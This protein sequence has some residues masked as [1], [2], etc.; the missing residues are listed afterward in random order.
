[1]MAATLTSA[2]FVTADSYAENPVQVRSVQPKQLTPAQIGTS[3]GDGRL[4]FLQPAVFDPLAERPDFAGKGIQPR[5]AKIGFSPYALVQFHQGSLA[6]KESLEAEGVEFVG[7]IPENAYQ[8][9]LSPRQRER[10]ES[11]PAVRWIGDYEPAWKVSPRLWPDGGNFS[12]DLDV[13]LFPRQHAGDFV[14]KLTSAYPS[15][16]VKFMGSDENAPIVTLA[17][18]LPARAEIVNAIAAID[19]VSWVEPHL[20]IALHNQDTIGPIQNNVLGETGR[21][22]FSRNLIGTGQI[23]AVTDSGVDAD[24][25]FFRNFNGNDAVTEATRTTGPEPGPLFPDRKIIGYWVQPG[26]DPYDDNE[27]CGESPTSFHGTHTSGTAVGDNLATLSS[28]TSPG[29]DRGDGM[30]PN[31]QLL[32]QDIGN[33]GGCLVGSGS[34][35]DLFLQALRGGARIHSNSYGSDSEGAY[36]TSDM[37]AD[38]FL[39]DNEQMTIFYSAGN[40]GP[41][42]STTGSPGNAKNVVTVGWSGASISTQLNSSSSRGPTQDNRIKP[43]L[44]APGS[45]IVSAGGDTTFGNGNCGTRVLQGTSM[46][47]PAVAGGSALLRQYF[48]EGMYPTGTRNAADRFRPNAPLVKAVLLNGTLALPAGGRFGDNGFGWGKLFLDNNLFFSGDARKLRVWN[49]PNVAGIKTGETQTH[50]VTVAA[51]QEFRATLVWSDPEAAPGAAISLV[52]NLDLTVSNGTE[53]F[54]GNVF[55]TAGE[56]VTGGSADARNNVEQVRFTA[57]V[58][59]TYTITVRG[60]NVP[61]TGRARTNRQGYALVASHATCNTAVTEAPT[62]VSAA[63]NANVGIDLQFTRPAGSTVIQVYRADACSTDSAD[64]Q[65][66]GSTTGT[67]FTDLSAQGGSSYAYRFRAADGC[68]EGPMSGCIFATATGLCD[69]SPTFAGVTTAT[70]DAGN[71]KIDLSWSPATS[72]C[73]TSTGLRYRIFRGTSPDFVPVG[74]PIAI[75]EGTSYSDTTVQSGTTYYYI[76]RAEDRFATTAATNTDANVRRA[77]A[78]PAGPPGAPGTWRD[79]A[80]DTNAFMVAETPWS[81]TT[82]QANDGTRSYRSALDGAVQS[83]D[84]TCASITTPPLLL[85]AGAELSYFAR[86]NLEVNWDGVVVEISTDNGSTW[87]DLPPTGD[88]PGQLSETG[89]PPVNACGF[90][91]TKRAFTGPAG[92]T[93]LTPWTEYKSSLAAFSGQ[94]VRIRWRFTSDPATAFEGF[95][96]DTISVTNVQ[97]PTACAAVTPQ[98]NFALTPRAPLTG[99]PI[100]FNDASSNATSYLWDFGDGTTSTEQ[101]PTHVYNAEGRYVVRLTVGNAGQTSVTTREIYVSSP[102]TVWVP[103]LVVPGQARAQ[104]SGGSLFRSALWMTNR[105]GQESAVRL[106]YIVPPGASKG[107]AEDVASIGL[108]PGRLVAFSDVLTE[109]LGANANTTGIIVVEVAQGSPTPIVTSR[110]YNEPGNAGTFG[111]YIPAIPIDSGSTAP[112]TIE[113]LGGSAAFRTNLG[114]V[115]LSETDITATVSL[116]DAANVKRGND[117]VRTIPARSAIQLNAI[118]NIASAGELPVFTARIS[119]DGPLFAYASKL[120]NVTSDPIFV[121]S[122]LTPESSQWIDGVAAITGGGGTVFRSNLV[123]ANR[124]A[125][126]ASVQVAFTARGETAP[127]S[128]Q[129]VQL[130]SGMTQFYSDVIPQLFNRQDQ[131]TLSI[132]TAGSTPVIAWARTYSDRGAAGTLGQFIPGFSSDELIGSSGAIL[133]GLSENAAVRTNMGLVNTSSSSVSVTVTVWRNDAT[134]VSQKTYNLV[135]GQAISINRVILDITGGQLSNGY[136]TI[137]PSAPG[138]VYAWASYVDNVSTDQTFVR[139]ILLP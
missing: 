126:P 27:S 68:G 19:E 135:G 84:Q 40:S 105:T 74:E 129:T 1:M 64:F 82:A 127:S 133:Q 20:P 48:E 99:V 67:T 98:A 93:G 26:A 95:F 134:Q 87:S 35:A 30:A 10:L 124:N 76:V 75:V 60:S 13:V 36:T 115:N 6:A 120:D 138:A 91:N 14:L 7:Y 45:S 53:T 37:T 118:N 94:T 110:T 123:L 63:A 12:S 49:V 54:L 73:A 80:G 103:R 57:P 44:V 111:Q 16:S 125:S 43:D 128:T 136:L 21:T 109:A 28:P 79:D 102:S 50:S 66:V 90:P 39:F 51:G 69:I 89:I 24:M 61:G 62:A 137:V 5:N 65:Y 25:C 85:A 132:T 29:S 77:F 81:I 33:A 130:D 22:L 108:A 46:A 52:N 42:P 88:Y 104:G 47:T 32:F 41:G 55:S 15:V 17:V 114:I 122:T 131:G 106:R 59:G 83:P 56:S 71:C 112:V 9:R 38:R 78:T 96:L 58:A 18:P 101:N 139:P 97:L 2:I 113:G 4:L 11:H 31:A 119:A 117:V 70:A 8:V 92:N 116:F 34:R 86:F 107:G 100:T 121:P 3:A 72:N 23:V